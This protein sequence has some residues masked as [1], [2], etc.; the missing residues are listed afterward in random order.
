M[1]LEGPPMKATEKQK[2]LKI[3]EDQPEDSS[4]D[5]IIRERILARMIE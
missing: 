2:A 3:L 1:T 5:E 4:Y